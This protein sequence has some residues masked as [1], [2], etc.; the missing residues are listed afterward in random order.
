MQYLW[1]L[2]V[3]NV[4]EGLLA[5]NLYPFIRLQRQAWLVSDVVLVM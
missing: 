5:E 1:M 2:F 3:G 4:Q